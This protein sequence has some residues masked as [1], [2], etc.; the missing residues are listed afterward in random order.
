MDRSLVGRDK[1]Y[2]SLR[3][4]IN[5]AFTEGHCGLILLDGDTGMGKSRMLQTLVDEA[6]VEVLRGRAQPDQPSPFQPICD[7]LRHARRKGIFPEEPSVLVK[8]LLPELGPVDAP[9]ANLEGTIAALAEALYLIHRKVGKLLL[10]LEDLHWGDS[11]TLQFIE[12]AADACEGVSV[13]FVIAINSRTPNLSDFFYNFHRKVR[14]SPFSEVYSLP[15][16]EP[17]GVQ[18]LANH[19]AERSL[20]EEELKWVTE[21]SRGIPLYVEVCV[22]ALA[23]QGEAEGAEV[24]SRGTPVL[25]VT[26]RDVLLNSL[27][28]LSDWARD[29]LITAAILGREFC[30][31]DLVGIEGN[32]DGLGELFDQGFLLDIATGQVVFHN[33]FIRQAILEDLSWS[34][35]RKRHT[36]VANHLEKTGASPVLLAHHL[37]EA[38]QYERACHHLLDG[39]EA[40]CRLHAYAEASHFLEQA[41]K[42]WPPG[43]ADDLR[44][45][46]LKQLSQCARFCG[47]LIKARDALERLLGERVIQANPQQLGEVLVDLSLVYSLLSKDDETLEFHRQA[48]EAFIAAGAFKQAAQEAVNLAEY[49][50]SRILLS[51]GAIA[52]EQAIELAQQVEEHG[53]RS[54]ALASLGVI[55]AMQGRTE[56]AKQLVEEGVTT[57]LNHNDMEAAVYAYRQIA[58]VYEYASDYRGDV[59]AQWR[60]L[61]FCKTHGKEDSAQICMGCLAYALL[62]IG[63]WKQALEICKDVVRAREAAGAARAIAEAVM[64]IIL[65]NRGEMRTAKRHLESAHETVRRIS[66]VPIEFNILWGLAL[67]AQANEAEE[68]A[69][70]LFLQLFDLWRRTEDCHDI[71]PSMLS[72][73]RFF[74]TRGEK[75]ELAICSEILNKVL[76]RNPNREA[77]AA[78]AT[79]LGEQELMA[80]NPKGA[81]SQYK[82]AFEDFDALEL[83][84]ELIH[85]AGRLGVAYFLA[86]AHEKG[87]DQFSRALQLARKLG[88]RG[89]A[90]R[91]T[92]W[93]TKAL[94]DAGINSSSLGSRGSPDH[95]KLTRRQIDVASGIADGL[96]NKEIAHRLNLSPRTVEMHVA[97]LLDRLDSRTRSEAIRKITDMGLLD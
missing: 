69:R 18:A 73:S 72:A 15:P 42:V 78:L 81:I 93:R 6:E 12:K 7:L 79:V 64:G 30:L 89:M 86:G 4:G 33:D 35:K 55:R 43:H 23:S 51:Q 20:S 83:P 1:E 16:L 75:K 5:R 96:T 61:E 19:L 24:V 25:P 21:K 80:G 62:R 39:A 41:L 32:E 9:K 48:V 31:P 37:I 67:M 45:D 46:T 70:S 57:A 60:A 50:L 65:L 10:V 14:R 49:C 26:I 66:L 36:A 58:H 34:E 68:Q 13:V 56:A 84:P 88:A 87:A 28:C 3:E 44:V 22:Q 97:R 76:D 53:L 27:S 59:D 11:A 63:D 85:V 2:N 91:I 82:T 52:A 74:G 94:R 90:A 77:R 38:H 40:S 95:V 71:I 17:E 47:Q 8:A 92:E 29:L 54:R